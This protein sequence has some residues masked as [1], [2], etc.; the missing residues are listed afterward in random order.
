M[1][2]KEETKIR[3]VISEFTKDLKANKDVDRNAFIDLIARRDVLQWVLVMANK[4]T[5]ED[6]KLANEDDIVIYQ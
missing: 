2:K 3:N 6:E 1:T 4:W 5:E